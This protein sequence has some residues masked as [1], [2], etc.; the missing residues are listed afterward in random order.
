[1]GS[2]TGGLIYTGQGH[3]DQRLE[4]PNKYIAENSRPPGV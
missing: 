2:K 4:G 3:G 1:M